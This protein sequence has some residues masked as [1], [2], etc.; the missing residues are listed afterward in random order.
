M[1]NKQSEH[2]K[3]PQQVAEEQAFIA[4]MAEP[5]PT[6]ALDDDTSIP[7]LKNAYLGKM[8]APWDS[9]FQSD[10]HRP[11]VALPDGE[12]PVLTQEVNP[13]VGDNQFALPSA[14][15]VALEDN[16]LASAS[17]AMENPES[18]ESKESLESQESLDVD[19]PV[20][21]DVFVEP[22]PAIQ[23]AK[24]THVAQ[25]SANTLPEAKSPQEEPVK[26][27]ARID[28]SSLDEMVVAMLPRIKL[29]VKKALLHELVEIEKGLLKK[30]EQRLLKEIIKELH[31]TGR[32]Q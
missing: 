4:M 14:E 31:E 2:V 20:L 21:T 19:I 3:S 18:L 25:H 16:P 15:P 13:L 11:N 30:I 32:Y 17:E 29:E 9:H 12:L 1:I 26:H 10:A 28:S 8:V 22:L 27:K 5:V 6:H 7:L 23:I 24:P